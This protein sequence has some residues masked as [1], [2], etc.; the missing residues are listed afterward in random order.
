MGGGVTPL[1]GK[2]VGKIGKIVPASANQRKRGKRRRKEGKRGRKRKKERRKE[3]M[4]NKR[5]K[6]NEEI[7][8]GMLSCR[9]K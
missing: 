4:K 9:P 3:K 7:M 6:I 5:R 2:S 8:W 1:F